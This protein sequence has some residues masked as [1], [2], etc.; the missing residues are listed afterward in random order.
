MPFPLTNYHDE[1]CATEWGHDVCDCAA[2]LTEERDDPPD[3]RDEDDLLDE[4]WYD[5]LGSEATAA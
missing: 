1:A 3:W 5:D 2:R 4:F